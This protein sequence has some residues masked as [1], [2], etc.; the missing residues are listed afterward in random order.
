M[1]M[2]GKILEKK[3]VM[4]QNMTEMCHAST[5]LEKPDGEIL[6]AWFGG[7]RE[8]ASDTGIYLSRRKKGGEFCIPEKMAGSTEAH[9]NPVLFSPDEKNIYLYYKVGMKIA[10]W[11]TYI[12]I[13]EDG[14]LTFGQEKELVKGDEGGRGPVKNKPI[15]LENGL[16]LAPGSLEKEEW[17]AFV[18]YS[19]DGA[20]IFQK[21]NM[22]RI[23]GLKEK[24]KGSFG[25][26]DGIEFDSEIPVSPQSFQ[27]RGVIQPTL[28]AE[29]EKNV[30]MLLRSSEGRIYRSDSTDGGKHWTDAVPTELLNNNS[31][32]DAARLP[33]G[34]IVLAHNPVGESWGD[35]TPL[36][37][38]VSEDGGNSFKRILNVEEGPGEYSYPAVV[39]GRESILLTYTY[40]RKNIMFC[41]IR[42]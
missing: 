30:H 10:C 3:L 5:V 11:R 39:A 38:S 37:I 13:S 20:G 32:I 28:W 29:D 31:G 42:L 36:S 12:R 18:D 2:Y 15:K 4:K 7:S 1:N 33:D 8:G 9:W 41:R 40:D 24:T 25:K 21:S 27:N 17:A 19:E 23:P 34:R 14:G 6:T 22:I 35:R 26:S 16:I